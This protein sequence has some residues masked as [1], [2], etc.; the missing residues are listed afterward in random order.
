MVYGQTWDPC[1][2]L[3]IMKRL[4]SFGYCA[5]LL[6]RYLLKTNN[7]FFKDTKGLCFN[8]RNEPGPVARQFDC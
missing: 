5:T 8:T 7:A 2:S 6:L 3:I 4:R 1:F